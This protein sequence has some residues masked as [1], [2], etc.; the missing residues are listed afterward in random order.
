MAITDKEQGVWEL[1]EVYNKINQ[2][3]IWSYTETFDLYSWGNNQSGV[4]GRNLAPSPTGNVS[5]PVLV[6][7]GWSGLWN[8]NATTGAFAFA[9]KNPGE[10]W[11]WGEN[12][13]GNLGDG[14]TK[15]RSSPTQI[16]GTWDNV[17]MDSAGGIGIK[18][19]TELYVWGYQNDGQLGLGNPGSE[20]RSSPA[21]IPGSWSSSRY[22]IARFG[23]NAGAVKTDGTLW[24][25]GDNSAGQLGQGNNTKESSPKQVPGTT[26]SAISYDGDDAA[27]ALETDGSGYTCG[28]NTY[29]QLGLNDTSNRNTFQQVPGTWERFSISSMRW[30]LGVKSDGTLW[31][32]GR[33]SAGNLGHNN[34]DNYSSPKQVGTDTTWVASKVSAGSGNCQ[35]VKS[36]GTLWVWGNCE[37]GELGLNQTNVSR[38]SP[39]QI[40]GT[41][42]HVNFGN[43]CMYALKVT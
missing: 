43:K 29:G 4:W 10:L 18:D 34:R 2:G 40:P 28:K 26:W 11:V 39:T 6:D 23:R 36:D 17:A 16:P 25:W 7:S 9:F 13:Y 14:T 24:V 35:A 15:K 27:A 19:S 21:Q 42:A 20:S 38:S 12:N 3:G 37:E 5:S 41:W 8:Q 30:G 22:A 1:D 31:T 32:W 33:N